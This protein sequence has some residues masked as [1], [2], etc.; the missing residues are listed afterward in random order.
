MFLLKV[1]TNNTYIK[2]VNP[3]LSNCSRIQATFKNSCSFV[4]TIKKL[5][6]ITHTHTHTHTHTRAHRYMYLKKETMLESVEQGLLYCEHYFTC[7][8]E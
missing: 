3:G 6:S 7:Y 5:F 4:A 1:L 2:N 8:R